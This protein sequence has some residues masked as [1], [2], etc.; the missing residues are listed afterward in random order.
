MKITDIKTHE[1]LGASNIDVRLHTPITLFCGGNGAG[2]S[3]L[4]ESIRMA[5]TGES[6][7]VSLKKEYGQLITNNGNT[8]Y[9]ELHGTD[10]GLEWDASMVLPSGKGQHSSDPYIGYVLDA[11]RFA[12]MDSNARRAFL[13]GLMNIK[14]DR[15]VV[16]ERL[17]NLKCDPV[18]VEAIMPV[19]RGGFDDACKEAQGKARDEKTTFRTITGETY[20]EKKAEG[21]RAEKPV[22]EA[23]KLE[24]LEKEIVEVNAQLTSAN[25]HYGALKSAVERQQQGQTKLAELR[26]KGSRYA[27]IADKLVR[28]EK[29]LLEWQAK[30]EDTRQRA[31]GGRKVGLV[32]DLARALCRYTIDIGDGYMHPEAVDAM[33]AYEA[34]FGELSLDEN[35]PDPEA[36]AK[37]PE[38]ENALNLMQRAV[39]NGKR[40]LAEADQAAA[41]IKVLE[42]QLSQPVSESDL[43]KAKASLGE[44]ARK[45]QA[46]S[47]SI[48]QLRDAERA[49]NDAECKTQ[50]AHIAHENV[51]AW[52]AIADA[53]APDGI[54]G[55]MLAEALQPINERLAQSALDT[56]WMHIRI[57][58]D[59]SIVGL[60]DGLPRPYNLLSKSEKWRVNAMIAEAI[61]HLSEVK[62]ITL[63][64]VDIL[65][66][67]GRDELIGWLETLADAGEIET[68]LLFATLKSLPVNM[69]DSVG[70]YWIE[71]GC[72]RGLREAA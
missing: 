25:Q 36:V 59:M 17:L 45:Q 3:S 9:V 49:A 30:V 46:L 18:K 7:R 58:P 31:S 41:Q 1:F 55:Q 11:Q 28:D 64:E 14:T 43:E 38:Y 4:Q 50:K 13:F 39:N 54:P 6:V 40:D 15:A 69:P 47:V 72:I 42:E 27:R 19:M 34:Q 52:S 61:S 53:L 21:W 57:D 67:A 8:G 24:A 71:Q 63:D 20:G 33:T 60:W 5:L 12:D 16:K 44:I 68:A 62:L 48:D 29:E 22:F 70:C 56:G 66:L 32:H 2:K 51:L 26:E 37:L 65:D 10:E 23:L 35:M